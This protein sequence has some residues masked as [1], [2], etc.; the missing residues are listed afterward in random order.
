[1]QGLL[2]EELYQECLADFAFT[3]PEDVP[4][5][6]SLI[7]VA[8]PDPQ[9]RFTFNWGGHDVPV[10]VPPTYLHWRRNDQQ[11]EKA[12][13]ELLEPEGYRVAQAVVPKKLLAVCSGLAAYGLNSIT[14]VE[15][16]G[17]FHRLAAFCSD[18][19][20]E[21]DQWREASVMERCGQCLRCARSC[22][23]GAI[24]PERHLPRAERCI[25][26]RNEKPGQVAFPQWVES[27]WHDS[28]VGC[29]HCQR[30]CP[31]NRGV[32]EWYEEGARFSEEE[33]RLLLTGVPAA[34]LP[35]ALA[36]KLG[37]WDLLELLDLLPRNLAV[38]LE[39]GRL[40]SA[41]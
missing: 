40:H 25:T 39:K 12:L 27:S 36:E 20:C 41:R 24:E 17:S 13:A 9:V 31:E 8:F 7:V 26:F 1:M 10:V 28:L 23:T 22:P 5:A 15:N 19:G 37:R 21:R 3:P 35:A 16:L 18:L 29:M 30:V 14:Y 33:T 34:E 11:V 6:R 32:L 4:G 38:L 2:D